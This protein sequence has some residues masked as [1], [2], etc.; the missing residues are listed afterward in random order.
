[1]ALRNAFEN[2]ATEAKQ[3]TII[4]H[5]DGIEALLTTI[6]ADTSNLSVVG[7][8]TETGALRVTIANNS[9]GVLSIDDN[10]GSITVDGTVAVTGTFWQ[11][12]QPVSNAGTFAVQVSSSLPTGSNTIGAVNIAAAQT[13]AT[14][15]TVGA[16]TS[17]TNALPAGTNAIGKLAA[18]SGV[19]I[20]DVDILSIIPGTGAT[21]L[22]KAVDS[23]AGAT[24]TGVV[25]LTVRDDTL[26]ALAPAD[27]DYTRLR[28][29]SVGRLWV[30][31]KVDTALP[32]GTN[33]IGDVD[34]LTLPSLPTGS[35]VIGGVTQ[36][37]TWN[38]NAITTLPSLPTGSN[39][40]G[41]VN[42][43][44]AQTLATVTTV[45][46]VTS[47]TNALPAGTNAIGKLAANSGV[48]IGDVDILSII[49]GTGATNLGKAVDNAAG[50]TDTGTLAIVVRDDALTTLTPVDNDYT[51]LRV[52]SVGRLWTSTTIDAALPAGSNAI[53]SITNTSF[54]ATQSGTWNIN[55]ITTLPSLPTGANTIGAVNIAAAQTLATVT[56]VGTVTTCNLAS[57]DTHDGA[58]GSSVVMN[59]GY[60]YGITVS[61]N[62]LP[63]VSANA[64]AARLLTN[65]NGALAIVNLPESC[66]AYAPSNATTTAYAN[67]L[68]VKSTPGTLYMVTGYNSSNSD[69]FIQIH[70]ASSLP[71][72]GATPKIIFFV[73]SKNNFSFD[74][75]QYGR[76]FDVG[77]VICTSST[78]PTKA[79]GTAA[80]C[81]IDA[82]YV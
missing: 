58:A 52:N 5:V 66:K 19:D 38:I 21:N 41:A 8:G 43:A 56:T 45:G 33:N 54:A 50:A 70:D 78:G 30:S 55:A 79:I 61:D 68:V 59:G 20:G 13:L 37:G 36:S 49:P 10:G 12:T 26:S 28:S 44:A 16:V 40:I 31:A 80:D 81:W 67:S 82:Q 14:V 29:D 76:F 6:D 74:L 71:S 60:A 3:T 65:K 1:M 17:I 18:N 69:Q 63:T 57:D 34:V 9:T 35:N 15:T 2:L 11:A 53:G 46:A 75:G 77:I 22:G 51:Q 42:I 73:P 48:D 62:T 27:G 72:D 7:G 39:T 64:D 25:A 23:V 47:I 4:G 24:D 32:A